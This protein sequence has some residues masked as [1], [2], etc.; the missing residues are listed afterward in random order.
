[1]S[2]N[3]E[4]NTKFDEEDYIITIQSNSI[5][6]LIITIEE[7]TN[8]VFWKKELDAQ[9]IGEI[10][11]QMGSYKSLEVFTKM[12]LCALKNE[13]ENISL[14]FCSL[15]EIQMLSESKKSNKEEMNISKGGEDNIKKYLMLVY[16][17]FE[18]VVY[19][20]QL[21]YLGKNPDSSL[22][23]KTINRM[24]EKIKNLSLNQNNSL[25]GSKNFLNDNNYA[26]NY[27]EFERL[28]KENNNLINRIKILE[29]YRPKGAVENDEIYKNYNILSEEYDNYK[30]LSD[31]KIKML[32]KT[33]EELRDTQNRAVRIDAS[34]K[35]KNK[36]KIR[37]LEDKLKSASET[38]NNERRQAQI[39]LEEKNKQIETLKKEVKQ[40][41]ENEKANKAKVSRLEKDLERSQQASAYYRYGTPKSNKSYRTG[42]NNSYTA[43]Y[44][45][46]FSESKRSNVSYIRKNLIPTTNKYTPSYTKF[47]HYKPL[48]FN[49]KKKSNN[50]SKNKSYGSKSRSKSKG[51]SSIKSGG[52][53]SSKGK[54]SYVGN[55]SK[56]SFKP[57]K[58]IHS[59]GYGKISPK[60]FSKPKVKNMPAK[61]S[62][63]KNKNNTTKISS[64]PSASKIPS[65]NITIT[66]TTNNVNS[67]TNSTFKKS[68]NM[69]VADRLGRLQELINFAKND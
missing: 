64:V 36:N 50:S 32:N 20:I 27:T 56:Y 8:T 65:T 51:P 22:L 11:T 24:K 44:M 4:F 39:F 55:R 28:K 15:N 33:I 35:D 29:S 42:S 19:P 10:T 67:S 63:G 3:M 26:V 66:R 37:D 25:M 69:S 52:S 49:S 41:K 53:S 23:Y 45:S 59:S 18:K 43:S 46:G 21:E 68:D 30:K 5:D 40:L 2:I 1:M 9:L 6:K 16:T 62:L 34:E 48:T 17:Q 13:N 58:E 31:S 47:S 38:L 60:P 57:T 12:L 14:N 7:E 54:T 61:G